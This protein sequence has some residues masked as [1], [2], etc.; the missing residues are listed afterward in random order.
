VDDAENP[1]QG[2]APPARSS[3]GQHAHSEVGAT[4]HSRANSPEALAEQKLAA[5]KNPR[6]EQVRY[7]LAQRYAQAGEYLNA[8]SS[9]EQAIRMQ[10]RLKQSAATE[11]AFS[12]MKEFVEFQRLITQ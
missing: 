2:T 6:N 7:A 11:A 8:L 9:L 5:E 1:V 12:K 3:R 10:P 4:W